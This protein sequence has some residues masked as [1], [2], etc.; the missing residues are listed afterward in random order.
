M[1]TPA[2]AY[3]FNLENIH[4][5]ISYNSGRKRYVAC[6][7]F[8]RGWVLILVL[9]V[10]SDALSTTRKQEV[11]QPAP[12]IS[13]A[14]QG[15]GLA[16]APWP[17][18]GGGAQNAGRGT[19]AAS[20][21][22]QPWTT[23]L[24]TDGAVGPPAL[25]ADGTVFV[26][27]RTLCALDGV[28][29]RQKWQQST[30]TTNT[31]GAVV[32]ARNT[33]YITGRTGDATNYKHGLYALDART[34]KAR[35]GFALKHDATNTPA[36]GAN[37]LIYV[38]CCDGLLFAVDSATGKQKWEFMLAEPVFHDPNVFKTILPVVMSSP[39][40]GPDGTVYTSRDRL[41]AID[42][43]TGKQ[44]WVMGLD[45]VRTGISPAVSS[46]GT[47]YIGAASGSGGMILAI[48]G[49]TGQP[50]WTFLTKG[51]AVYSAPALDENSTLY[52]GSADKNLYA[53]DAHTGRLRWQF[54]TGGWITA[55]PV[56]GADHAIY[57]GSADGRIYA[58][59]SNTGQAQWVVS[60]NSPVSC[61]IAL[62]NCGLLYTT[63]QNGLVHALRASDGAKSKPAAP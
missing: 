30:I 23:A 4:M 41:Y 54:A 37:G 10:Q 45:G 7:A 62:G 42:G 12:L 63:A 13:S 55:A 16:S 24:F 9:G 46:D 52:V 53:L 40:I 3:K 48:D 56:V 38:Q 28:T 60:L 5:N 21:A 19:S 44:K 29:G 1:K 39:T 22:R 61:A 20:P 51:D 36:L 43:E 50:R 33:V 6:F 59:D 31:S 18:F 11:E 34:G 15:Q 27:G 14:A 2:S 47:V 57:C 32:D 49:A 58:L 35:W 17:K 8:R 25:G 26:T